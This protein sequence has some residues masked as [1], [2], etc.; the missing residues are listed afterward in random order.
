ML[1]AFAFLTVGISLKLALFPLH[2]WLPDSYTHA[3]VAVAA[4]LAGTATKVAFYVLLRFFFTIF[5]PAFLHE[6]RLDVFLVPLAL[7]AIF[8]GALVAIFQDD[9]RRMLAYSTISQI[10]Y[11]VLGLGL[12]ISPEAPVESSVHGLTGGIV[13]LFNHA[14][15]KTGL[16]LVMGCLAFRLGS[17]RLE[18]LRGAGRRMPVTMFA[19]VLGGLSLIGAPLTAGFISKWY[20]VL[21]ALERG[22]WPVAGL[23]LLSSLLAVV[24]VWRVVE[25]AYFQE[26]PEGKTRVTEAPLAMLVPMGILIA[27]TL[28]FG[29][30]AGLTAGVAEQAARMLLGV[31]P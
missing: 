13:H 14:L 7:T 16:F 19:F 28:V 18:D 6:L 25:V 24:Y 17:V 20:L 23:I 30:W 9:I 11:M 2:Q 12:A 1:V 10:G 22:W 4:F 3:P 15:T 21:G 31:A 5:G 26:P 29:T 8:V 27:A